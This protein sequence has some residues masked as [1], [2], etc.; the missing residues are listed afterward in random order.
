MTIRR[1]FIKQ[2]QIDDDG[3]VTIDGSDAKHIRLVLR[4][5]KG[6]RIGLI[7]ERENLH[8]AT[9]DKV[10][11]KA[12]TA[13]ISE[14]NAGASHRARLSVIQGIPRLPKADL[15][16]QKL[17]E[18][19][20][21]SITFVST[22]RTPYRDGEKRIFDRLERLDR[23]A[24]SASKQCLRSAVADVTVCSD[25]EAAINALG[26]DVFMLVADESSRGTSLR[27]CVSK[28][29]ANVPIVVFIGPEGG[30]SECELQLLKQAGAASF[31]L[32]RN[33]LR[34]E[35]AAIVAAAL[36]LYEMGEI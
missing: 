29:D 12:V 22:E 23:I 21:E 31:S 25:L 18:L 4:L 7:D 36:I 10:T 27:D 8:Q 15:I 32:G 6:D 16:V 30:F 11:Q 5:T 2:S 19:G 17:T 3:V 24:E 34:T 28:A 9:L 35:T 20:V 26:S 33:I 14:T 13:R 1:F